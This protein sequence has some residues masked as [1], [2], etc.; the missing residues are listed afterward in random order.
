MMKVL[1][2]DFEVCIF[3]EWE[4]QSPL[5]SC[6]QLRGWQRRWACLTV[7]GHTGSEAKELWVTYCDTSD[8]SSLP[9]CNT[10]PAHSTHKLQYPIK[11]IN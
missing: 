11:I 5:L 3:I 7:A 6:K 9:A 8:L 2:R 10:C 4:K 1:I